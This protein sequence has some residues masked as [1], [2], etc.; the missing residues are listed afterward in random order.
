MKRRVPVS[1]VFLAVVLMQLTGCTRSVE[2]GPAEP[3]TFHDPGIGYTVVIGEFNPKLRLS[4]T[5]AKQHSSV[6]RNGQVVA[7][8]VQASADTGATTSASISSS[9]F[10]LY[11]A[12]LRAALRPVTTGDFDADLTAAGYTPWADPPAG[13]AVDGWITYIAAGVR[14]PD[15]CVVYYLRYDPPGPGNYHGQKFFNQ[16]FLLNWIV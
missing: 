1:L 5:S 10:Y 16:T 11:C 7:L 12:P 3:R 8:H 9:S 15:Y 6:I 13:Q 2:A 4:S 14:N